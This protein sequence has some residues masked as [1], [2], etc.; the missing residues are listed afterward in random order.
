MNKTRIQILLDEH[1][2]VDRPERNL[3]MIELLE[4]LLDTDYD[5]DLGKTK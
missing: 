1:Y 3:V 5:P 4:A 2:K